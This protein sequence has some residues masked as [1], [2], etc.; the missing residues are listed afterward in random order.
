MPISLLSTIN[1]HQFNYRWYPSLFQTKDPSGSG[2]SVPQSIDSNTSP[3][4]QWCVK[5]LSAYDTKNCLTQL[6]N[7]ITKGETIILKDWEECFPQ[8]VLSLLR[9][10]TIHSA[11][12]AEFIYF[13]E[14]TLKLDPRFYLFLLRT[15]P[16]TSEVDK[17]TMKQV[18]H[19]CTA[20]DFSMNVHAV[21]EQL[22]RQ[23]LEKVPIDLKILIFNIFFYIN[24]S[25]F[26]IDFDF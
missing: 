26:H 7:A 8:A 17:K 16:P 3:Y 23:L 6:E 13:N 24:F 9:Q 20:V 4:S 18:I 1:N 22:N 11:D 21:Q 5:I 15:I 19:L 2:I 10:Q 12:G 14:K 25:N